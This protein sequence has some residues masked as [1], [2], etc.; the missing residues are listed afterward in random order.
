[1]WRL[2]Q[3]ARRNLG[4]NLIPPDVMCR[5]RAEVILEMDRGDNDRWTKWRLELPE[6]EFTVRRAT[7]LSM[8][9]HYDFAQHVTVI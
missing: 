3:E 7:V 9:V 5:P 8:G 2:R 1:M 4:V 6:A